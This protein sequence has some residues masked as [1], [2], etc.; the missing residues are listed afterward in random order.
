MRDGRANFLLVD[1]NEPNLLALSGILRRG[2]VELLQARSGRDALEL[3]LHHDIALAIIDVQMPN[4]DGFELAELMRG[5]QRTRHVPIIF[6][7]AGPQDNLHRFHGYKVGAVDF[8]YKPIE[9]AVLRSKTDIFLDLYRQREELARQRDEF[10]VMA[11]EKARLLQERDEAN[12]RLIESE[13]RFRTLAD[14]A[15]VLIWMNGLDGCEF[16]NRAYLE[17]LGIT[18]PRDVEKFHWAQYVH[19]EDREDYVATYL[20]ALERHVRFEATYRFLRGDGAYRWMRS[21]GIPGFSSRGEFTGYVGASFDMTDSKEA[22]ER[23]QR[24]SVD[25]ERAVN[26]KTAELIQSQDQ[27]RALATELNL[28]EQ[29]ERQRL[30]SELHDHLA[31]MLVLGKLKLSQTKQIHDLPPAGLGFLTEI[32]DVLTQSL[33][34]TRTLVADLAPPVLHEFGLSA[35]L[36]WLAEQMQRYELTV[37]V[38]STGTEDLRLPADRAVLIFQSVRELLMN[39]VKHARAER[40]SVLLARRGDELRIEVRDRGAGFELAS[41][42]AVADNATVPGFGLFS[43]RERMLALGG[44]FELTSAPGQG[45][46]ATL[47]L[48]LP[49]KAIGAAGAETGIPN[50][51]LSHAGRMSLQPHKTSRRD[52]STSAGQHSAL[53]SQARVRVLVADDHAMVRQGLR[54]ALDNYAD[55]QVVGEAAN[56]EEAVRLAGQIRPDVVLMDVNMP[57]MD[58]I[59]ATR[60]I[61]KDFPAVMVIG[62]SVQNAEPVRIAMKQ[63]GAIVFLNKDAAIADLYQT[64]QAARNI[65]EPPVRRQGY[66]L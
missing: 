41:L 63:A 57:K 58:G 60:R 2:D 28:A 13:M 15:P 61:K 25:L 49:P 53:P 47:V 66:F 65:S 36:P 1:D 54:G 17:F 34:Y 21:V 32:E 18:D 52:R 27:L 31:Q 62:L 20:N 46:T 7:T 12:R 29:R 22:E 38:E 40:A 59:E 42:A 44:R 24:W 23:L 37:N 6:L 30:A 33:I 35:A 10:L 64:I 43:I 4:M 9:P 39:A 55:I 14:S 48:P 45:T 8:L 50:D 11:E 51:E 3:L 19:P 5:T 56:G 16:V 26:Q